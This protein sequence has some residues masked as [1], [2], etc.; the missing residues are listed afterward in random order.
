MKKV[1]LMS[2]ALCFTSLVA[3]SQTTWNLAGNSNLA[4]GAF[5]GT[6]DGGA[7]KIRTNNVD[8]LIVMP[9]G[10]IQFGPNVNEQRWRLSSQAFTDGKL[11]I[12]PDNGGSPD[13][14][15]ALTINP[16]T[17]TFIFGNETALGHMI[18]GK[19][20]GLSNNN[21]IGYMAFN[22]QRGSTTWYNNAGAG[23]GLMWC[24]KSGSLLF[25]PLYGTSSSSAGW[26]T[27]NDINARKTLEVRWNNT[28]NLGQVVIGPQTLTTGSHTNFRLSVDGK[29]LAKEIYVTAS[30]WAD[31]VFDKNYELK[32]LAEVEA[33]IN[34]NRHLPN[35]PSAKDISEQG[36]NMGDTDRL[37]LEKIEEL[38][39]YIIAQEKR[40]KELEEKNDK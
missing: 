31:Y 26:Y 10:E 28:A 23:G 6:T 11:F 36:N 12:L 4:P 13:Y 8:R 25:A 17:G 37:L 16:A 27:D 38:T 20:A 21:G 24:N 34:E 5:L 30:N 35:I 29:V 22:L 32:P 3:K 33:F 19:G 40:I 39:L 9:S 15:S 1:M 18:T 14:S 2:V 7:L